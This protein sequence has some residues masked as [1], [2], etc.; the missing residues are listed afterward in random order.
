MKESLKSIICKKCIRMILMAFLLLFTVTSVYPLIWLVFFSFKSNQEIFGGNIMGPPQIWQV[1]NYENALLG[2]KVLGYLGNS[3]LVAV[4]VIVV[5][6]ILIS[7]V[8]YAVTRMRWKLRG[9]AYW[10][11]MAGLTIPIHAT[12]LPLFILFKKINILNTP[13]AIVIPYIVFALPFG[14]M[15]L[16]NHYATVP[17]E[18]EEAA[19]IDGCNIYQTFFRV[20]LPLVRPALATIAIFTFLSSWNELMFAMTFIS[21]EKYKTLTVG[22]QSLAGMYYTEWGPIGAGMV[23]ATFPVLLIYIL[24]SKQVQNA[25]LAGAVKG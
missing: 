9:A 7:M 8:A 17:Y 20:I 15:V 5:S 14:I 10:F 21:D 3:V 6:T 4:V 16:G 11:F 13:L 23:V 2:G 19:C 25:I 18:M 24:L 1:K 12:L 22:I